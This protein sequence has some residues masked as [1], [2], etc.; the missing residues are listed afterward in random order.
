ME[1][2]AEIF[3]KLEKLYAD[4]E[5]TLQ[6]KQ[7]AQNPCGSC[8]ECCT[9]SLN[10]HN[11][12]QLERDYIGERVGTEKLPDFERFTQ[13]STER[14]PTLCPYF[15]EDLWGCGIYHHR[16]F[17]C[18]VFG[19]HRARETQLPQVCVFRGQEAIFGQ[20]SYYQSVPL[21][22]RLR[23][24]VREFW[25]YE[26]T[27]EPSGRSNSTSYT[28]LS[29]GDELDQAL[30]LQAEGKLQEA[31][32]LMA[33]SDLAQTPYSLYCASLILEGLGRHRDALRA[34][35]EAL[36]EA[37]H[38]EIL[39]FRRACNLL[40]AGL[41][42]EGIGALRQTLERRSDHQQAL[43]LLGGQ[44]LREGRIIEA[45]GY[46]ERAL[47]LAPNDT[48]ASRLLAVAVAGET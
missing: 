45:R 16:P 28:D 4:F 17:S 39:H 38:S 48:S 15:D 18:R 29:Q 9:G 25:P 3:H 24:L 13:R 26:S 11:V 43:T 35:D 41:S 6:P 36:L 10:L 42:S 33:G 30:Q 12:T 8:R 14:G 32:E 22:A 37:E 27:G 34:L 1:R 47:E 5:R 46:L 19:H 44:L 21:A 40:A 31:L 2:R 20:A 7:A 23:E